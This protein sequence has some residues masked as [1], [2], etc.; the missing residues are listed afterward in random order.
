MITPMVVALGLTI[1]CTPHTTTCTY[2]VT[3]TAPGRPALVWYEHAGAQVYDSLSSRNADGDHT[4]WSLTLTD[5]DHPSMR[6]QD[7]GVGTPWPTLT[8]TITV[9]GALVAHST[10]V[11]TVDCDG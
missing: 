6:V 3:S 7:R 11:Q 2:S 4:P 8:C 1:T 10:A 9:D 5:V